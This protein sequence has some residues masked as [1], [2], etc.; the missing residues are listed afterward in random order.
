MEDYKPSKWKI[1]DGAIKRPAIESYIQA[2][3]FMWWFFKRLSEFYR[4]FYLFL[5]RKRVCFKLIWGCYVIV[6][7]SQIGSD[8][9]WVF[10][11]LAF[12]GKIIMPNFL[13]FWMSV[14]AALPYMY[15]PHCWQRK[16][17]W[18]ALLRKS[19]SYFSCYWL[20]FMQHVM[21]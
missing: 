16:G 13:Q 9:A 6:H 21:L 2:K 14:I 18:L 11:H 4:Q 3:K 10:L 19:V 20:F 1:V 15:K 12:N 8:L 5:D 17:I 7:P